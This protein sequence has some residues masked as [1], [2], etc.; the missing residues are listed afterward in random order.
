M[1][2][3]TVG[4]GVTIRMEFRNGNS[5]VDPDTVTLRVKQPDGTQ[6]EF[7]FAD[8]EIERTEQGVYERALIADIPGKWLYKAVGTGVDSAAADY[9]YFVV[10]KTPLD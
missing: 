9:K 10:A 5:L 8:D 2:G 4:Q 1:S 7:T 3:Y 6:S